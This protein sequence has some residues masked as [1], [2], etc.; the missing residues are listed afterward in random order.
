MSPDTRLGVCFYLVPVRHIQEGW[1]QSCDSGLPIME[2][3]QHPE[4]ADIFDKRLITA[5]LIN[6]RPLVCSR[7]GADAL[8]RRYH[9]FWGVPLC[10]AARQEPWDNKWDACKFTGKGVIFQ[11]AAVKAFVACIGW[12]RSKWAQLLL[13]GPKKKKLRVP[14]F[15]PL[16]VNIS[17]CAPS[18]L[19][20]PL[21][22]PCLLH[23]RAGIPAA[24]CESCSVITTH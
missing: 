14:L 5:L 12:Q 11:I 18:A 22:R 20:P 6:A 10:G 7:R 17:R 1:P 9:C 3:P 4:E 23:V 21:R 2:A 13:L 16:H 24:V 15:K 8:F 19:S